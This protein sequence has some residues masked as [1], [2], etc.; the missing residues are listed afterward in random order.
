M[1]NSDDSDGYIQLKLKTE[2]AP[3]VSPGRHKKKKKH[4]TKSDVEYD[5]VPPMN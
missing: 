4:G 5:A 2:A 1:P 3:P